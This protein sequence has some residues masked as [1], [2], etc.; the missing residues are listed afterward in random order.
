MTS[1]NNDDPVIQKMVA[2]IAKKMVEAESRKFE[3]ASKAI[4]EKVQELAHEYC[5]R[6]TNEERRNSLRTD[7]IQYLQNDGFV[8]FA[9]NKVWVNVLS[10]IY[11]HPWSFR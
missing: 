10:G 3:T 1:I 9:A 6:N 7:A 11:D 2:E 4:K 8:N 5:S